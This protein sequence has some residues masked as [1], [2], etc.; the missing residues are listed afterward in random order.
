MQYT[1]AQTPRQLANVTDLKQAFRLVSPQVRDAATQ[2]AEQL[3]SLG[4]S[5]AL[6]G[7]LA[8]AAHGY[9]RATDDVDFLVS[10]EAFEKRGQLVT[11]RAGMPIEVGGVRIDYLS[12]DAL[13]DHVR[14]ALGQ[15]G[16]SVVPLD[17]L[18]YMKL[19]AR[20]RKDQLDVVEL[21]RRTTQLETVRAYLKTHAVDLLPLFEVLAAEALS[22]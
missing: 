16:L 5:Y 20:R 9:L 21:L 3:E 12:P 15:K 22:D 8:V 10:D 11:F 2:A 7:G 13:G 4:V 19:V 1:Y 14:T 6:A 18:I 17:I